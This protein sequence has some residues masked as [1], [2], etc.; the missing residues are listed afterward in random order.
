[1]IESLLTSV[2]IT[3]IP[4]WWIIPWTYYKCWDVWWVYIEN[5]I[6]IC[7]I[8]GSNFEFVKYHE[9]WH[10]FWFKIMSDSQRDEYSKKYSSAKK[11]FRDYWKT[12]I[13]EDFADNFA[14]VVLKQKNLSVNDR[15]LLIKKYIKSWLK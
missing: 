9:L 12:S 10:H 8:S 5:K 3:I 15:L 13:V 14:L 7:D 6:Y 1:M 4:L 11:F 2:V